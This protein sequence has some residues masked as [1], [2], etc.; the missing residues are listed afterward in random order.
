MGDGVQGMGDGE[1]FDRAMSTA[2]PSDS[3]PPRG[4]AADVAAGL[5]VAAVSLAVLVATEPRLAI[6][7]DEGYT[8]G[9]EARLRAWFVAL[10]DP[11]AFAARW[12]P[13]V[14]DLVPPNPIPAPGRDQLS[15]RAGLYA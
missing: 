12:Q 10:R 1:E 11:A 13:P 3:R 9:R 6:V 5:A 7:W 2:D 14:E 4:R 15:T 8:L